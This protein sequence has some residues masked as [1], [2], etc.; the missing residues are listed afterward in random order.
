MALGGALPLNITCCMTIFSLL[1]MM[2]Y[3]WAQCRV[4]GRQDLHIPKY[5]GP[6]RFM[7]YGDLWRFQLQTKSFSPQ[8]NGLSRAQISYST[9]NPTSLA[10]DNTLHQEVIWYNSICVT[11]FT[12]WDNVI[13]HPRH[14]YKSVRVTGE[15][16]NHACHAKNRSSDISCCRQGL[17]STMKQGR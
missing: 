15:Q 16:M 6:E 14:L 3:P 2:L 5:A 12:P 7:G 10:C 11:W 17:L 9:N 1:I 8:N 4:P 13:D